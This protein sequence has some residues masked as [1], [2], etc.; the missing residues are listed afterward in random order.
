MIV[1]KYVSYG[2]TAAFAG[3]LAMAAAA[4]T[5]LFLNF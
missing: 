5:G 1:S 4:S 2:I 3:L